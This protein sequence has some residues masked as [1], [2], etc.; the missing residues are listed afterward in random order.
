MT[1]RRER[2]IKLLGILVE[3]MD[4]MTQ[5]FS[6]IEQTATKPALVTRQILQA[7]ECGRLQPGQKLPPERTL[8]EQMGV[9]R[10]AI[11]EGTSALRIV[12]ILRSKPGD[13][14]YVAGLPDGYRDFRYAISLAQEGSTLLE[15][16]EAREELE[17]TLLRLVL[18]KGLIADAGRLQVFLDAMHEAAE[19]ESVTSFLDANTDFH[20]GIAKLARNKPLE[21]ALRALLKLSFR[22]VAEEFHLG[23]T[24]A[25]M[26]ASVADHDEIL[27]A[28]L[29]FEDEAALTRAM[30][31]HYTSM[32]NYFIETYLKGR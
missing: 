12:G 28:L 14:T 16:W 11:R 20:L 19:T 7:I 6:R 15:V 32:R 23:Y 25:R 2:G 1:S 26:Q 17:I 21:E 13:G 8:S 5:D 29:H 24:R 22:E 10:N 9:T 27:N 3:Q 31:S 18:S 30:R 4:N